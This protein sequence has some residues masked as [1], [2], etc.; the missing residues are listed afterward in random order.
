MVLSCSVISEMV[1]SPPPAAPLAGEPPRGVLVAR[2][3]D[4]VL[5]LFILLL[6]FY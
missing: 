2:F 6:R 4:I 5:E 1:S 3:F